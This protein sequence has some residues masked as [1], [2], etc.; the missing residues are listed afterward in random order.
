M[1]LV[2]MVASVVVA[3]VGCK[4][5][6]ETN[7]ECAPTCASKAC[8]PDGCGGVCGLCGPGLACGVAGTCISSFC[9]NGEVDNGESCDS[10]ITE[11]VGVCAT[12]CVDDGNSCTN[13]NFFGTA[14]DC[15]ARCAP[16]S[17]IACVDDDGCCPSG[18]GPTNDLDCSANCDNG[19]IDEG[20]T[21]DPPSSCPTEASCDDADACTADSL[22]GSAANCSAQCANLPITECVN[23]D[24]CCALGCDLTND[25]DCNSTCGDAT[26]T[27]AEE[28]DSAIAAGAPG[29]CP[30]DAAACDDADACTTENF[31]GSEDDCSASCNRVS[32]TA[33]TS[34]DGCC[35]AGCTPAMDTDCTAV[36]DNGTIET[37]ETCDPVATCPTACNDNDACTTDALMGVALM[38]TSECSFTAITACNVVAD[39]CC[40]S[41]CT[42]GNDGDCA[43]LCTTYCDAAIANCTAGNEIYVDNAACL[44]ACQTMVVG[45][46]ADTDKNTLYCRIGFANLAPG[47]AALYCPYAGMDGGGMCIN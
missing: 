23:G 13:E 31:T 21:C 39:Q 34:G 22:T 16:F 6:V 10:A 3:L 18:C 32:I 14:A 8:G 40:P 24:G 47:D 30:A 29:A 11:G 15:D 12:A 43:D 41:N 20:E 17:I 25:D 36:C 27:G 9:G 38:C 33:C 44:A 26:V 42:P 2:W 1:K 45:L 35:P 7:R 28:C 37:G 5:D 19:M 46:A 4:G